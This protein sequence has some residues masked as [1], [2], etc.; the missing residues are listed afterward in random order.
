MVDLLHRRIIKISSQ[1]K[2]EVKVWL[3]VEMLESLIRCVGRY[4]VKQLKSWCLVPQLSQPADLNDL[5]TH[6]FDN[7]LGYLSTHSSTRVGLI[8]LMIDAIQSVMFNFTLS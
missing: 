2:K 5:A 1:R 6:A 4:S 7:K 3:S 8:G